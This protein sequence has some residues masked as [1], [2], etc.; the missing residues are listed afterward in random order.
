M[1]PR[2]VSLALC[3]VT[4]AGWSWGCRDSEPRLSHAAIERSAEDPLLID[5]TVDAGVDFRHDNG[6]AGR[7]S[8]VEIMGSGAALLDCDDDGDLDLVL[9]QGGPVP[10]SGAEGPG[11]TDRLLRNE[12]VR[13]EAVQPVLSF[14]DA[15]EASGLVEA[16]YGMGAATGDYDGD[17]RQDLYLTN[18]GPNRLLRALGDCRFEDVTLRSG[19]GGEAWTVA[20]TFLDIDRDGDLDLWE[21][22]YVLYPEAGVE[23]CRNARGEPDYCTPRAFRAAPD[24]IYRNLGGGRFEDASE[25]LGLRTVAA[26]RTLGAIAFDA[27]GDGRVDLFLAHDAGENHFWSSRRDRTLVER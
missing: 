15:T 26:D 9:R 7:F 3:V 6:A 25:A 16:G 17:G 12:L 11:P 24:R 1:I 13:D 23:P 10:G 8:F 14:V 20:A 27:D 22:N 18:V 2:S 4:A 21:G 5:V 19:T